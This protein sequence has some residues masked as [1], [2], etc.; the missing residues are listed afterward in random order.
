MAK[1]YHSYMGEKTQKTLKELRKEALIIGIFSVVGLELAPY[2]DSISMGWSMFG[3]AWH[4][5]AIFSF[6]AIS[7]YSINK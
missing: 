4:A 5:L 3:T 7:L 1:V 2:F 6:G